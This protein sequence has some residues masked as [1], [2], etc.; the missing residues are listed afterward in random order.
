M[1]DTLFILLLA[2]LILGPR[3]LPQIARQL[4][5]LLMQFRQI[6]S[7]FERQLDAEVSIITTEE[8]TE[9]AVKLPL[10]VLR[11]NDDK[12]SLLAAPDL[13]SAEAELDSTSLLAG[14]TNVTERLPTP[15]ERQPF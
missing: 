13:E 8:S 14:A 9:T 1:I 7:D 2:L 3:K 11:T 5:G 4:G 6:R 12:L 15:E 10:T